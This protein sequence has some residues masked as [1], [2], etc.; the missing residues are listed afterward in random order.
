[1]PL[2]RAAIPISTL[3]AYLLAVTA[4]NLFHTHGVSGCGDSARHACGGCCGH[5]AAEPP[6]DPRPLAPEDCDSCPVCHF[7]GHKPAPV[8]LVEEVTSTPVEERVEP[9]AVV[10]LSVGAPSSQHSRAPPCSV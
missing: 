3:T 4:G 5:A 7:Q 6:G 1:M 9:P 10:R 8:E 2:L